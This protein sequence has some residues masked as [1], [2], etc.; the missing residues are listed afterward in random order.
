METPEVHSP[1]RHPSRRRGH[2]S[3]PQWLELAVALTALVTSVSSIVIAV[4]HG[5]TMD[6]LV[7]ANSFPYLNVDFSD[8]TPDGTRSLTLD[9]FNEGVGPAHEESLRLK[10]HGHYVRSVSE[11]IAAALRGKAT[12]DE[13]GSLQP[14]VNTERTR[15]IPGGQKQ[16]IFQIPKNSLNAAAWEK[17]D[18]ARGQ[19]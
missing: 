6:K 16:T 12:P 19:S 10:V 9:M 5:H 4:Q 18:R 7:K 11:L 1:H 14:T 15:F 8:V 3:L 13:L 17:L 2:G